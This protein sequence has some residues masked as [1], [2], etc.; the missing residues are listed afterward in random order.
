MK[1]RSAFESRQKTINKLLKG[2]RGNTKAIFMEYSSSVGLE[3]W[4]IASCSPQSD[5]IHPPERP[6]WQWQEKEEGDVTKPI[7]NIKYHVQTPLLNNAI[8][9]EGI[10]NVQHISF[11]PWSPVCCSVFPV[12][13]ITDLY[14]W[15]KE[16]KKKKA[17][18][19]KC[20]VC[21][22]LC[23]QEGVHPYTNTKECQTNLMN[24]LLWPVN[25][26]PTFPPLGK[27]NTR[28]LKTV[29]HKALIAF[30]S[31]NCR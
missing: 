25:H 5:Q 11:W 10:Q 29:F 31:G 9:W 3:S 6:Y 24:Y 8:S 17:V 23:K 26:P 1:Q 15:Q 7:E 27:K 19:L 12:H 2:R 28:F 14:Y 18:A 4:A 13:Y 16:V 21:A 20:T 22:A 30:V